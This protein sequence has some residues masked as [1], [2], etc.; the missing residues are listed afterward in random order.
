MSRYRVVLAV[1]VAV[2]FL[3]GLVTAVTPTTPSTPAASA[4]TSRADAV[5]ALLDRR[6]RAVLDRDESAFTADL[7]PRADSGFRQRQRDLFRNLAAVP[8][9][10]GEYLAEWGSGAV[11]DL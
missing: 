1:L 4:A 7:D 3:A 10:E 11:V 2:T 8:L 6:A 9:A 5:R